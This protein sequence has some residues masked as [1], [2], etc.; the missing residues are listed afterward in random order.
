MEPLLKIK[1]PYVKYKY[2]KGLLLHSSCNIP[3]NS[4]HVQ[5]ES[6]RSS[7]FQTVSERFNTVSDHFKTVFN[8]FIYHLSITDFSFSERVPS[9]F[10]ANFLF[11]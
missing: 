4:L 3:I 8:F 10:K 7:T 9:V 1:V 5:H 2:D 11:T 6:F